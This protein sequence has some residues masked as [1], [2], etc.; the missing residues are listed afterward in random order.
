MGR[1]KN[2][3]S[4]AAGFNI[5]GQQPIDSRLVVDNVADLYLAETWNGVGLYNGLVVAIKSTGSLFVLKDRDNFADTSSWVAVGG[6]LS[7]D[8]AALTSRVGVVETAVAPAATSG[9]ELSEGALKVKIDAATDNA[10]KVTEA[11]LK[12]VAPVYDLKAV[13]TPDAQ[14]ASQYVFS[15]DGVDVTTINIPK[16]Q[17]LKDAK[18]NP[19]SECLELTFVTTEGEST[20][21]VD[22]SALVDTYTG[23][24]YINVSA[25]QITLDVESLKNTLGIG[26]LFA[27]IE[28]LDKE[29]GG[30]V[31]ILESE[32]RGEGGVKATIE[33]QAA[34]ITGIQGQIDGINTTVGNHTTAI[35]G[36]AATLESCTVRTVDTSATYGIALTHTNE[37]GDDEINDTVGISVDIDTLAAAVIAKHEVPAP[38][39][40]AVKLAADVGSNTVAAGATVQSTLANLESRI[41]AAVSG[42]VTGI[43]AGTGISVNATDVNNPTVSVVTAD[44]VAEGSALQVTDNKIDIVWSQ[45]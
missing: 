4:L 16:D 35:Q 34:T 33:A 21:D 22:V 26:G 20:V 37:L 6:D 30:R 41:Q 36:L 2:T 38:D 11:G 15:K 7:A 5:T 17:F 39:A 28:A 32:I 31:A 13:A 44:L 25:N 40:S 1:G 10:I 14:Y 45:L 12:V 42:G 3:F 27:R 24:E 9:L 29:Q 43:A 23:S 19:S 8:L 18:Y